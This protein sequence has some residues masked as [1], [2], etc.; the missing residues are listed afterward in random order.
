VT[1]QL[2][3]VISLLL[4]GSAVGFA[5][6]ARKS[7][8]AVD[9]KPPAVKPPAVK[10]PAV[11][12]PAVRP[13][14]FDPTAFRKT[15]GERAQRNLPPRLATFEGAEA[16]Y[17]EH[18]T[19][20]R[21]RVHSFQLTE[22]GMHAQIDPLPTAGLADKTTGWRISVI[23]ELLSVTD[24][25]FHA[26]SPLSFIVYFHPEVIR[27]ATEVGANRATGE[28]DREHLMKLRACL[29]ESSDFIQNI[30]FKG[31]VN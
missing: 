4:V 18:D 13:G 29:N 10:P 25:D 1:F 31:R 6:F 17:R 16:I 22:W 2:G 14:S 26:E 11:K 9:S 30:R 23:W 19:I 12:P 21:V 24:W 3:A 20:A 8:P 5:V 15:K 27:R 28:S 7:R